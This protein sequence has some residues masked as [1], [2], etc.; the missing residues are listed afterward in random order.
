MT[1]II[2]ADWSVHSLAIAKVAQAAGIPMITNIST[3]ED[4]TKTGNYIFRV[5]FIDSFQGQVMAQ[6]ARDDL[7][8]TSAVIF[9]NIT[10]NYSM[11][12]SR[13][14]QNIF[15]GS[16]GRFYSPHHINLT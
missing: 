3:N 15:E 5:C 13:E 14:F 10:S 9:T 1:A 6:F 7:K 4:V 16:G 8:A 12:L 2:G 11:G